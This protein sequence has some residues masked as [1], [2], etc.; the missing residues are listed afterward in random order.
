MKKTLD[1]AAY[2]LTNGNYIVGVKKGLD[3]QKVVFDNACMIKGTDIS[4]QKDTE[5]LQ[6]LYEQ[7][8]KTVI[9]LGYERVNSP[10]PVLRFTYTVK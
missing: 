9:K 2:K 6:S 4:L 8:S 7:G 10:E 3:G 1:V 5:L